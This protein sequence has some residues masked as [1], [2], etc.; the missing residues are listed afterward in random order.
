[1]YAVLVLGLRW[2]LEERVR[3]WQLWGIVLV[4]AFAQEGLQLWGAARLP[5]W[6]E[7]FDLLV[8]AG[9]ATIGWMIWRFLRGRQA[10]AN[11]EVKT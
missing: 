1:M 8:D 9:G 11:D 7:G 4:V 5:G 3:K 10:D 6:G 2:L